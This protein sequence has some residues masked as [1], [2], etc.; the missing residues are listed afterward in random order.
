MYFKDISNIIIFN[1]LI[2]RFTFYIILI[3]SAVN[4]SSIYTEFHLLCY[5]LVQIYEINLFKIYTDFSLCFFFVLA[6]SIYAILN[7]VKKLRNE[8]FA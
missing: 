6:H 3:F 2:L 4:N 8:Y 7:R 5:C 1:I